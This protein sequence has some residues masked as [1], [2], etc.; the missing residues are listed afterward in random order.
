M[1][2]CTFPQNTKHMNVEKWRK[3]IKFENLEEQLSNLWKIEQE[4]FQILEYSKKNWKLAN[5]LILEHV[6]NNTEFPSSN[7]KLYRCRL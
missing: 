7:D 1:I 5:E 2:T 3:V 6:L 4:V